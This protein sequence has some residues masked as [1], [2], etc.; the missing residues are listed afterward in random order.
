MTKTF[1]FENRTFH[2]DSSIHQKTDIDLIECIRIIKLKHSKQA[3]MHLD[4]MQLSVSER[5]MAEIA[6][7]AA[8]ILW[9][10]DNFIGW[11]P[12][13]ETSVATRQDTD[14][15]PIGDV[16]N[17]NADSNGETI[18]QSE[19]GFLSQLLKNEGR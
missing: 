10:Y 7:L 1:N 2:E 5:N 15:P 6:I 11:K 8:G 18:V 16:P 4:G 17:D 9:M 13:S 19:E 14:T 12:D 3:Q